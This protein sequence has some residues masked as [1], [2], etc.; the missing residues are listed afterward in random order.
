MPQEGQLAKLDAYLLNV[1][2]MVSRRA[3]LRQLWPLLM[4]LL[5]GRWVTKRPAEVKS[6]TLPARIHAVPAAVLGTG[7]VLEQR[8]H[9]CLPP[10][11][12]PS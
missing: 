3:R 8:H 11:R 12:L 2:E 5:W 9:G 1:E 7:A 4:Q 10:P 6:G